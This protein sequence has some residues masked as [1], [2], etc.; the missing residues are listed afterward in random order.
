MTLTQM[1]VGESERLSRLL[2]DFIDFSRVRIG[3]LDSVSL[4]DLL[5]DCVTVIERHP[6]A[7]ERGVRVE[8]VSGATEL[9]VPAD[10]DLLHR[11]LFN[12]ILN[13]V[14]FSPDDAVVEVAVNDLRN[15]GTAGIDVINPIQIRIRDSGP[16]V[17]DDQIALGIDPS[18]LYRK[19]SR[20]GLGDS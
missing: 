12:L 2:S 11:A 8:L 15:G 1:I 9:S 13:A 3:Q 10:G 18:T 5:A 17:P 19:I 4:D 14:Q 7:E 6:D 20:Y 16:G